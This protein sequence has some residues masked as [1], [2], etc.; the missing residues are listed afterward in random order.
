MCLRAATSVLLH[1]RY[2]T[3]MNVPCALSRKVNLLKAAVASLYIYCTPVEVQRIDLLGITILWRQHTTWLSEAYK[4]H[5]CFCE[6]IIC[7]CSL[8][9][10]MYSLPVWS[11]HFFFD[12]T[13]LLIFLQRGPGCK[14]WRCLSLDDEGIQPHHHLFSNS[15]TVSKHLNSMKNSI[16]LYWAHGVE[17]L[18]LYLYHK[19]RR[20]FDDDFCHLFV[21]RHGPLGWAIT[22]QIHEYPESIINWAKYF[23][24]LLL[25]E[26]R[27]CRLLGRAQ[28]I[29]AG[30]LWDRHRLYWQFLG[31]LNLP[32][33]RLSR[34][35]RTIFATPAWVR[36]LYSAVSPPSHLV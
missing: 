26:T 30:L 35:R 36:L 16:D 1:V 21:I 22:M 15:A 25:M 8:R 14:S 24:L 13:V 17:K 19:G 12:A 28:T 18:R 31:F 11:K 3:R 32:R 4:F 10:E 34:K 27:L 7:S 20:R 23:S 5:V 9:Q 2:C 6:Y 29:S 33:L